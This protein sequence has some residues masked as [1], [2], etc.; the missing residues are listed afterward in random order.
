[1]KNSY[2]GISLEKCCCLLGISR[3]AYYQH[4]WELE[5]VGFEQEIILSEVRS[6]R[7]LHPVIGGRKLY[8]MLQPCLIEHKIKMGRDALFDLLAAHH[9]LVRKKKRRVYTTQ[10]F[11]WLRKY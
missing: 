1:M 5:A 8:T 2:P 4:F 11:H 9:L 3:Q 7:N 6:I 10:S